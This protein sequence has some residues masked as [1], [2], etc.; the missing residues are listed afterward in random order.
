MSTVHALCTGICAAASRSSTV[1]GI[2]SGP[3][4]TH[5][6]SGT[7]AFHGGSGVIMYFSDDLPHERRE[8]LRDG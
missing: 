5:R 3:A 4:R 7:P 2:A 6:A 1:A 8:P